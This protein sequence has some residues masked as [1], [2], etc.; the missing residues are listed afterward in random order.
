MKILKLL[1]IA[2]DQIRFNKKISLLII[3]LI[4]ISTTSMGLI[5]FYE[6]IYNYSELSCKE[7][8]STTM[9]KVGLISIKGD[10]Y[11]SEDALS[12]LREAKNSEKVSNIGSVE[13]FK[14]ND[15]L[16]E[17]ASIQNRYSSQNQN[18]ELEWIYMD[19]TVIDIC[20][21][22]FDKKIKENITRVKKNVFYLFLGCNFKDIK[23]G[24]EYHEKI[25]DSTEQ[26]YVVAGV[27]KKGQKF[28]TDDITMGGGAGTTVSTRRLDN[29]VIFTG[30]VYPTISR[31]IYSA[32]NSTSLKEAEGYLS[33]LASKYNIE[34]SFSSLSANFSYSKM[35]TE[36]IQYIFRELFVLTAIGTI[37]INLCMFTILF[38]NRMKDYGILYANGFSSR[39]LQSVFILESLIKCSIGCFLAASIIYCT[40]RHFFAFDSETLI[41][42]NYIFLNHI[43]WHLLAFD[44][45]IVIF[46]SIV[47]YVLLKRYPPN[48]LMKGTIV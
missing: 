37:I 36:Q 34:M 2:T 29:A 15:R 7:A 24:T 47:P 35:K 44:I 16:S 3:L 32:S 11:Y 20:N 17:L 25:D 27:L 8:L 10:A 41:M 38:F 1:I 22:S 19:K 28:I 9:D 4:C 31:W 18:G 33:K 12:F 43:V 40:I 23:V 26:I 14:V 39:E 13:T 21:L 30:D 5:S 45:L 42:V 48:K 6:R 46:F